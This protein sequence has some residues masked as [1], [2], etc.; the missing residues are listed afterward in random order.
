MKDLKGGWFIGDFKPTLLQTPN[1][2]VC[3]KEHAQGEIWDTHY[4][5]LG[6][7]Y[8]YL[9]EGSMIVQGV[10]LNAGDIFV[11]QP[12]EVADPIFLEDCKV[13]IVKTPSV[14]GDKYIV[15]GV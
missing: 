6:T 7:E 4:H 13:V 1:F 15:D 9:A 12:Y 10:T 3:Y 2:E 14:V 11:I 5:K 8:N